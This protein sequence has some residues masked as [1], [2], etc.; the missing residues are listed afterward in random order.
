MPL[1]SIHD[2]L[3]TTAKHKHLLN[4]EMKLLIMKATTLEVK[5]ELEQWR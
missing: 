4:K 5:I 3:V 1:A 2:C